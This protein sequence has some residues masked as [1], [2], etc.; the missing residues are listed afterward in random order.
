M[1]LAIFSK[2]NFIVCKTKL[3]IV[4]SLLHELLVWL[5]SVI[6]YLHVFY[7]ILSYC[8]YK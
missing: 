7:A 4:S 6:R 5:S 2:A 3:E 8:Y 1:L